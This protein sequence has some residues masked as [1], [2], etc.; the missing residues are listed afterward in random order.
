MDQQVNKHKERLRKRY[1]QGGLSGFLDYEVLE[2]ILSYSLIRKDTKPLAKKLIR[3]FG[4]LTGVVNAPLELL[5][6]ID[7][8]GERTALLL[9]LVKDAGVFHLREDLLR[10]RM[11]RDAKDVVD[12]LTFAYKGVLDEQFKVVYLN[13]KNMIIFEETLFHGIV[14]QARIYLRTLV[15]HVVLSHAA[16]IIVVHNHPGG[17]PTPS[18]EDIHL[19]RKI[20]EAL[21]LVETQ[22]LDHII[23]AGT[24]FTSLKSEGLLL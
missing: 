24:H 12:Y 19:T 14:N 6:E 3:Q 23:I 20:R 2:L 21:E 10:N 15:K 11:I 18:P 5:L 13:T 16:S 4:S 7:G 22:L 9:K 17:D 1:I 8:I